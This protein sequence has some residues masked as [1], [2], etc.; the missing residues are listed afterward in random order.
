MGSHL[1]LQRV[2]CGGPGMLRHLFRT[3]PRPRFETAQIRHSVSNS[4]PHFLPCLALAVALSQHVVVWCCPELR[5][6][7]PPVRKARR[8]TALQ[9]P[10]QLAYARNLFYLPQ[11]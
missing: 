8:G 6:Y 11:R 10:A 4:H 2:Q 5:Q 9:L 7:T 1:D 3:L